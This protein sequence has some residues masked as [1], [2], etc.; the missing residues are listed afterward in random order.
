MDLH[1]QGELPVLMQ[2]LGDSLYLTT[3]R[4]PESDELN[5]QG[6][7]NSSLPFIINRI[8]L[9]ENANC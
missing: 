1:D 2:E 4:E 7:P 9:H 5:A 6:F 3:E 8:I